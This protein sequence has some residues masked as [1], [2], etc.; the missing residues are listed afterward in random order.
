[1]NLNFNDFQK[2]DVKFNI[3][4]LQ[5]AYKEILKIKDFNG[6]EGVSN[7]GA[8]SLTQ[9]PGDPESIKGNKAR[10][11][12]WTKPNSK[13]IEVIRDEK[14]DEGAY[15]EFIDDYKNTYFKE[16]YDILSSKYKLGR[17]RI[18]LKEPRSTLSWHRDPEP[19]LH[20]PIIT[21]PGAIMVVDNIAKHLPADGSVWITNNTKYHNAFNGGEEDR[22]H[23][24]ACVL[25]Y[26]FN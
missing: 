26:K 17:V 9:I 14:I 10:G 19:R 24:V 11:V 18:L 15:S 22:I 3:S 16:V 5:K 21:N 6:P 13:G 4:K 20:I 1:M 23:L 8:I 2:Q 12:F 25:D 7:F